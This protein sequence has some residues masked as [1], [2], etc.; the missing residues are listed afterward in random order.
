MIAFGSFIPNWALP[1]GKPM[2]VLAALYL[3]GG[4]KIPEFGT[5][6]ERSLLSL[7]ERR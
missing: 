3:D 4:L 5:L 6:M 2:K 7:R 1:P